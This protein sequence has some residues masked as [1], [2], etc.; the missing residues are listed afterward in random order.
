MK[1][2]L[3][4]VP[5][6]AGFAYVTLSSSS[7][8]GAFGSAADGGRATSAAKTCAQS[9]CHAL[10]T[11][12]SV[13]LSLKDSLGNYVTKYI[14]NHT[15]YITDSAWVTGT[16]LP[17]TCL[18]FGF[19]VA[20]VDSVGAGTSSAVDAGTLATTGL[21]TNVRNS[22]L[23]GP[24]IRVLE[25]SAKHNITTGTGGVGSTYVISGLPWKAPSN[26]AKKVKI[27]GCVNAV[28]D[29]GSASNLD[30]YNNAS[31]I[32]IRPDS[33]GYF[34]LNVAGTSQ[35]ADVKAFP[36]PVSNM[37]TIQAGNA[38]AGEYT[39]RV[40]DLSGKCHLTQTVQ[41][42]ASVQ[43]ANISTANWAA[44][45]YQVVLQKEGFSKVISVVKQ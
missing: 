17:G 31:A 27:Y 44:G 8:G 16:G 14:P 28:N 38:Q 21:P 25:H 7:S 3:L 37:L 40:F 30:A 10:I 34:S 22:S 6:I 26:L 32:T 1:K 12:L 5:V 2:S 9:G 24:S 29:D 23:T 20:V 45:L 39:V 43:S 33:V 36:N 13:K 41:L 18:K 42:N 15:Y 19:Q 35:L 4:L 11:N